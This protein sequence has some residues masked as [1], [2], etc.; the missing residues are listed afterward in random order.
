MSINSIIVESKNDQIFIQSI[1]NHLNL[2]SIVVDTP[3]CIDDGDFT[4]L[5]GLD[6]N[7][8]KPSL[9]ITK[10]KDIKSDILKLGITNIGIILDVDDGNESTK[11]LMINTAISEVFQDSLVINPI[12]RTSASTRIVYHDQSVNISCFFLNVDGHGELETV[13]KSIA[14][15]PSDY[16]DCLSAWRDCITKKGKSISDK[17]YVKFWISNYIRFDTCSRE[18]SRHASKYCS[19]SNFDY[20]LTEK[21]LFNLDSPLLDDLKDYLRLFS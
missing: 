3:I 21:H 12:V 6:A 8:R 7:P 2:E 9:L 20:V 10:L 4:C 16:A 18:D 5:N 17:E 19:M 14:S 13:L 1:V 15:K 11:L